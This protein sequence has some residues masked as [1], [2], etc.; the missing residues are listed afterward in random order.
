MAQC[1]HYE[2][3]GRDALEGTGEG[4][5]I[6]HSNNL[7]K[8]TKAF[9]EALAEHRKEKGED[10]TRFV[11][12]GHADFNE[13]TFIGFP[14]FAHTRFIQEADFSN[15]KFNEGADFSYAKFTKFASF[16]GATFTKRAYWSDVEFS[17]AA[18]F[19]GA[20]FFGPA[21]FFNATFIRDAKF[22]RAEFARGATFTLAKFN[23]W[24][25][26]EKTTFRETAFFKDA[27][28]VTRA[29][30]F[31]ANFLADASF[32]RATFNK[33]ADFSGTTFSTKVDFPWVEFLGRTLFLSREANG[34]PIP[35]F[36]G[37]VA[38]FR[39][40]AIAPLDALAFRDADLQKCLFEGTDLRKV[41]FAG[42]KWTQIINKRWPKIIRK[43]WPTIVSRNGV[44]DEIRAEEKGETDK[45]P[46]IEQLYRQLKQNY[47]D[48]KDY[49]RAGQ[50]HYSEKEMRRRNP[51]TSWGLRCWLTLY[52]LVSGYGER[53]LPPLL[54]AAGLLVVCA[55]LYLF[56]G[57]YPK[58]GGP[59]LVWTSAWDW[60][61][62]AF[63]SFRVITLLR[64]DDLAPIGYAKL[65]HALESL[66]GPLLLGLFA[67]AIR[68]KLKR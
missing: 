18:E 27:E 35:I 33:G 22:S 56:L 3:C 44:Y 48:R 47:E 38:N 24:T 68:Q 16:F 66:L 63:Y 46:L 62:S 29:H 59:A 1:K 28:F 5:C 55:V 34:H 17:E 42:V 19:S 40:V 60:L 45:Y 43:R 20:K 36:S 41:E 37:A 10:F 53:W 65:V 13:A 26:F 14:S 49:E 15:V 54:Y 51:E 58:N 23:D 50:F 32:T 57:L 39:Q 12:P 2:I 25:F 4:L 31:D 11:F 67:L 61:R 6:L 8:D 9:D 21:N 7:E 52:L 30:F 64:P